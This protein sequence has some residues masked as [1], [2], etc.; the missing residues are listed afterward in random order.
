[1]IF[2]RGC[3]VDISDLL[4][5][6]SLI[7]DALPAQ[8][9]YGAW[10]C[11]IQTSLDSSLV[12]VPVLWAIASGI[13]LG[14]LF[15]V[16]PWDYPELT[17]LYSSQNSYWREPALWSTQVIVLCTAL[18]AALALLTGKRFAKYFALGY[19]AIWL[20]IANRNN[21]AF[22]LITSRNFGG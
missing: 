4:S 3:T 14:T 20:I 11:A 19:L 1:M 22:Q 13:V 15:Q 9:V 18:V 21:T 17:A 16:Y 10:P 8:D 5:P 12:L 7:F 6:F 2:V